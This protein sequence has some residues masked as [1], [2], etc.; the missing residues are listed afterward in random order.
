MTINKFNFF[1]STASLFKEIDVEKRTHNHVFIE[2]PDYISE[3]GSRYWYGSDENGDYVIRASNHW[4]YFESDITYDRR[5]GSDVSTCNWG[6]ELRSLEELALYSEYNLI[7]RI[8]YG[9][10]YFKEFKINL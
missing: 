1:K 2:D 6:L 9:I 4:T 5:E 3:S 7:T 10:S 8:R